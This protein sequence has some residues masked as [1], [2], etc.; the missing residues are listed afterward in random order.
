MKYEPNPKHKEPWSRGQKGSLCP[1][2][3]DSAGLLKDSVS[4][5]RK[6]YA[7]LDGRAYCA[8]SHRDGVWHGYPVGWSEVPECLRNRWK[9]E[10]R[11]R[12][13]DIQRNWLG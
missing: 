4:V 11:I 9:K 3:I 10:G 8:R 5:G 13:S 2:D 7:H 6:R 1:K 12:R